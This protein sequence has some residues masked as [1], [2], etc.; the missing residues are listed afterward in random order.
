[1]LT[2]SIADNLVKY[3]K[4]KLVENDGQ[5]R[6]VY[7]TH[8]DDLGSS[9]PIFNEDGIVKSLNNEFDIEDFKS[10]KFTNRLGEEVFSI[11]SGS[12]ALQPQQS[13]AI[14]VLE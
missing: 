8:S 4:A 9:T 7:A 2:N 13:D 1:M 3:I 11:R 14:T 6:V 10:I 12:N 5:L